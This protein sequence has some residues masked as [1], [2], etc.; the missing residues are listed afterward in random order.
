MKTVDSCLLLDDEKSI[1]KAALRFEDERAASAVPPHFVDRLVNAL[2]PDECF[3][4]CANGQPRAVLLSRGGFLR[5][6]DRATFGE[7]QT[8]EAFSPWR[9]VSVSDRFTYS[10]RQC[11]M[12]LGLL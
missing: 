7:G 4:F 12:K 5:R 8:G 11:G 9:S 6:F 3:R 2:Q 10:S 1:K